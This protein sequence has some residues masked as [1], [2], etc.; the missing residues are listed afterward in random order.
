MGVTGL[1][2]GKHPLEFELV[3]RS[4][5][6][7]TRPAIERADYRCENCP[8]DDGLRV[9]AFGEY[10]VVLCASCRI[11]GGMKRVVGLRKAKGIR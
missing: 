3:D 9:C 8:R 1:L 6:R 2:L 4:D 10:V 7:R 5:V 11:D